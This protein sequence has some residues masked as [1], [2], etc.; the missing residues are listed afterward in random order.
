MG[1]IHAGDEVMAADGSI[2]VVDAVYPQGVKPI[3]RIT[4]SDGSAARSTGDHLWKVLED[5][6][7][8]YEVLPLEAVMRGVAAGRRYG[9]PGFGAR[10]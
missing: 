3:Y 9:V 1:E 2:T 6:A 4:L 5:G 8:E 7:A 10:V